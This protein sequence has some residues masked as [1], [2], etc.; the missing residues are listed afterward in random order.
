[1]LFENEVIAQVVDVQRAPNGQHLHTVTVTKDFQVN[2]IVDLQVDMAR[3]IAVSKNHT[4]THMLDQ[5][6]RLIIGGD[7]HQAGSLVEPDYLRFDFTNDGPVDATQLRAIEDLVNEKIAENL[8]ISWV[9]TDIET[10]QKMGAVAVFGEK[11]G[12]TVRV[13]S[14]GDFNKEFDGGTHAKSTA[15]LGLFK[16][17]S[18]SGIG[19]GIRRIEAVT[20]L[21]ALQQ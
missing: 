17:V 10:A 15:E 18:E 2:D 1:M 20:G 14:I 7:V 4:A 3:H 13:V 16:I 8:P 6:L 5:S 12:E 11:Y 19:A 21:V 9:E